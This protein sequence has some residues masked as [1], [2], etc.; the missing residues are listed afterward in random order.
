[1][2]E[3]AERIAKILEY[4]SL[5]AAAFADKIGVQRSG[6]SHILTGRNKPSLDF[7][8]KITDAFDAVDLNWLVHGK[9]SF[10]KN[11]AVEKAKTPEQISPKLST[12]PPPE[13]V[14]KA[15][16]SKVILD[17]NE[18]TKIILF[19]KDGTFTEFSPR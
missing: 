16:E 6:L 17:S 15:V 18:V 19:Y 8:I 11:T 13:I 10:P 3:I 1:M 12:S 4:Y 5:N 9:G 2:E 14:E 7:I